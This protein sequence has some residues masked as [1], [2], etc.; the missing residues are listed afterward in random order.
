MGIAHGSAWRRTRLLIAVSAATIVSL[1]LTGAAGANGASRAQTASGEGTAAAP[2][3]PADWSVRPATDAVRR[4]LGPDMVK[5]IRLVAEQP[6]D[7]VDHYRISARQGH[8]VI[9]GTTPAVLLKGVNAY[10]SD[11]AGMNISWNGEQTGPAGRL[12]L[13][14]REIFQA[15]N[16]AHRFALNDTD[17]GY[18]GPYR[19]WEDWERT[20]DVLALHGVNEVFVPVGAEAVY[21]DT[22]RQFGYSEKELLDWIPQPGHQPWWLLQNMC[23][24]PSPVSRDLVERRA[25]M[26][27]RIVQR[28]RELGMTPV[29]PG[30]FGTV[31]PAFAE[32]NPGANVVDQGSWVGFD[33][34]DWLDPTSG[35]FTAVADAFYRNSRGRFGASGMYKMDLL[36]EGGLAGNVNVPEASRAVESALHRAHPD[37][38]WVIL[39]WQNNPRPDTISAVDRSKMLVVDGL[40]D[41]FQNLDRETSWSGT[42]YAFGS[43]W[44]FGGHTTMGANIGVWN[45]RYW[46]WKNKN[47]SALDGIAIMPEASDNN[48]VALDFLASLAWTDGPQDMDHWYAD[49]ADRR[50]GSP[51]PAA[52]KAWQ[53]IGRTAYAMPSGSWSEAQDGLFAAQPSLST[54]TAAAYSPTEMRYDATAFAQAL[55]DLLRVAP[56]L[57]R[58]SAYKYDLMDVTRQ[59][60]SNSSRDLL[61]RIKAAYDAGELDRFRVLTAQWLRE[62]DLLEEVTATNSQTMLGPW[63]ADARSMATTEEEADALERDA[64]GLVT[65]WGGRSGA[66]AGLRDYANREWSGLIATYYKPRWKTYFTEL[67]AALTEKRD[68]KSIDWYAIGDA[69]ARGADGSGPFPTRPSG[70]ITAIAAEVVDHVSAHPA[71]LTVT[72]GSEDQ[73]VTPGQPATVTIA[74]RNPNPFT[75]A[76]QVTVGLDAPDGLLVRPTGA[77]VGTTLASGGQTSGT[78]EVSLREGEAPQTLVSTLTAKVGYR[79]GTTSGEVSARLRLMTAEGVQEPNRTVTFNQAVFGQRGEDY[80]IAGGGAD[81]WGAT[82]QFGAIYRP[83]ALTS[84]RQVTTRVVAQDDTGPWAR[85]GIIARGDLTRQGSTGFVNLA[86]TP[87]NGCVLSWDATGDGRLES[88]ANAAGFRDAA[89]LR[90]ERDGNTYIGQ[91]SSDGRTWTQ[92]GSA[93]LPSDT[94][95]DVG[96]FMTAAGSGRGLAQFHGFDVA[97]PPAP[98]PPTP[99]VHYLSDLP[100]VSS[101]GG[102]GPWERDTHNGEGAAGDGGPITLQ[103]KV[104]AKGLGTNADAEAV[105]FMGGKCTR[106]TSLVGIDD[107]MNKADA[108][109]DVEFQVWTDGAKAYNTGVVRAG[110]EPRAIDIDLTGVNNLRLV[111]TKVDVNNWWDRSDWADAKVTCS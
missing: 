93:T 46:E 75:A 65:V 62:M 44:N 91:C 42:P 53:A 107:T 106:F 74:V 92:V 105:L 27:A 37:A 71:P 48:P 23:C 38:I 109:G 57:K 64:R 26:G 97:A 36:H 3:R 78:F 102:L 40:S 45:Q 13:P 81:L 66:E 73:S 95:A 1:V 18:T 108:D 63:L 90:L 34:P 50:Y 15:A 8:V 84:G 99:G 25:A 55:P 16:V 6:A 89:Y 70:D 2:V 51:D 21:L 35:A 41:R 68:P 12:P 30:Y 14:D 32:K 69:W 100:F 67:E 111:V 60:L 85:A 80:V 88:Y 98:E 103:G 77:P 87:A 61:P 19:T 83:D 79:V 58:S 11:I 49:W 110:E 82:N 96:L 59:V 22:F 10:L 43:I 4:L 9:G 17:D 86:L 28:L 7:G 47:G 94:A 76:A 72:V 104:Y 101:T 33:R 24:F 52:Q 5:R 56:Q 31:P 54:R 20:I 39:G 29:L